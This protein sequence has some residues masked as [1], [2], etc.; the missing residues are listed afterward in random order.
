[1][2][3]RFLI[4][5]LSI[6]F[7]FACSNK[8]KKL[9]IYEITIVEPPERRALINF[10]KE[11]SIKFNSLDTASVRSIALDSIWLWGDKISSKEFMQR[12]YKG[13]SDSLFSGILDTNKIIYSS[14]GC[15]PSPA[16]A[17]AIRRQYSDAFNCE[18][19]LIVQDTTGSVVNGIGFSFLQTSEGYRLFSL[20]YSSSYWRYDNPVDTTTIDR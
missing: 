11:F 20:K 17:E 14:I 2:R 3:V 9:K 6:S 13:Y 15:H 1:M 18:E 12:Y 4:F 16:I 5:A 7:L 8:S 10:W 19:V